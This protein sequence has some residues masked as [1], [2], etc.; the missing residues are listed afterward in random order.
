[1][2]SYTTGD[3]FQ[4][5]ARQCKPSPPA[6]SPRVAPPSPTLSRVQKGR[7]V[8]EPLQL[9]SAAKGALLQAA[10]SPPPTSS[11]PSL[12]LQP[13]VGGETSTA[14]L[15]A[16]EASGG[17]LRRTARSKAGSA[18]PAANQAASASRSQAKALPPHQQ[19]TPPPPASTHHQPSTLLPLRRGSSPPGTMPSRLSL[20]ST[21]TGPPA[22]EPARNG[23]PSRFLLTVVPPLHLPHDPPHP[24]TSGA[25]SGYGPPSQFR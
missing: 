17:L 23:G 13:L 4:S 16:G 11:E 1:M 9:K 3:A 18:A 14:A 15:E 19:P 2:I 22:S 21:Q 5:P 10:D 7:F 6:A 20:A 12:V 25:C 8:P 24:R